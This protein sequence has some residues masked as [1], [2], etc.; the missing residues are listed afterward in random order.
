MNRREFSKGIMML[1]MGVEADA[2]AGAFNKLALR[3]HQKARSW[4]G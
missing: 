3:R 1:G 2:T 4:Q